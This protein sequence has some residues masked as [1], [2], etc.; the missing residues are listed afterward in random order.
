MQWLLVPLS[1][2]DV[3]V[4]DERV[5]YRSRRHWMAV[6]PEIVQFFAAALLYLV[7]VLGGA[8]GSGLVV[9][10]SLAFAVAVLYPLV[11]GDQWRRAMPFGVAAIAFAALVLGM[12]P[13]GIGSLVV[14]A[15]AARAAIRVLRWS[16]FQRTYLTDRRIMEVDGFLGTKV[17]SM[18]LTKVT[19]VVL[20]RSALGEILG[21]GT[22]KVENAGQDQAL[23]RLDYL[24][25]PERFHHLVV[26]GPS[27]L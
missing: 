20:H 12:S 8:I 26:E 5:L 4:A 18:P 17:N 7:L 25:E 19:D 10:A 1:D 24:L 9:F 15:M 6:V 27:W 14:I 22:F 3:L 16:S 21:Y 13:L 23:G 11:R 2:G